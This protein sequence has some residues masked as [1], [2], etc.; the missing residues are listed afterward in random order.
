MPAFTPQSLDTVLNAVTWTAIVPPDNFDHVTVSNLMGAATLR[1]RTVATDATTELVIPAGTERVVIQSPPR[2]NTNPSAKQ[3]NY[4]FPSGVV[5]F[6]MKADSGTGT[7]GS[8]V[9]A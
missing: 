4:R 5:A 3:V 2:L 7:G 8:L 1:V 6:S 9:W